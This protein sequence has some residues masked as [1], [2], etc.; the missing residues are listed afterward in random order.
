MMQPGGDPGLAFEAGA[1]PGVE[2]A[3]ANQDLQGH[4]P[5]QGFLLGFVDDPHSAAPDLAEDAEVAQPLQGHLR[6]GQPG[7]AEAPGGV[8]RPRLERL[9]QAQR[10]QQRLDAIGQLGM[11]A[12]VF[13]DRRTLAPSQPLEILLGDGLQVL[14]GLRIDVR[15]VLSLLTLSDGRDPGGPGPGRA[16]R[17]CS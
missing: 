9:D 6:T 7:R 11:A 1:E 16:D 17:G 14:I 5:A 8:A 3:A 12:T 2:E 13:R 4:A 15:H 10:R